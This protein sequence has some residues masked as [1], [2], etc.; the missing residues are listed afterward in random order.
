[1][2]LKQ[3]IDDRR[4]GA[5]LT[6]NVYVQVTLTSCQTTF[7]GWSDTVSV[8]GLSVETDIPSGYLGQ[9][10]LVTITFSG[11]HSN[12]VIDNLEGKVARC[13][14]GVVGISFLHPLEW[15]VLFPVYQGK[16]KN[17]RER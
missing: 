15:F 5:R 3:D 7:S 12:L 9:A 16:M 8:S 17:D 6:Y 1:M 11:D 13:S 4:T 10:A 2:Q 14:D